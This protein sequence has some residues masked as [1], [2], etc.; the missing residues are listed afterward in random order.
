MFRSDWLHN[1]PARGCLILAALLFASA[2]HAQ[3]KRDTPDPSPEAQREQKGGTGPPPQPQRD[4]NSKGYRSNCDK[5]KDREEADLCE[6]RR[7]ADAAEK[8]LVWAE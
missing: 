7:M 1:L 6:Q 3:D 2:S 8:G 5:P 4:V